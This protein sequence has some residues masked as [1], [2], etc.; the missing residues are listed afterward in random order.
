LLKGPKPH[1]KQFTNIY[2]LLKLDISSALLNL[3]WVSSE[4]FSSWIFITRT[5]LG[6]QCPRL[7]KVF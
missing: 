2:I 3:S 4:K 1:A 5:K 6:E 7:I